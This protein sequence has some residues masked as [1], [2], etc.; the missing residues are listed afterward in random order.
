M[1][2]RTPLLALAAFALPAM[3]ADPIIS[4]SRL[5]DRRAAH[6]AARDEDGLAAT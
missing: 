6:R 4:D 1:N 3:A 5:L 2:V